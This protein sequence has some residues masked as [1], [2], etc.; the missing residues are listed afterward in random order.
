MEQRI[1]LSVL[2]LLCY[3]LFKCESLPQHGEWAKDM[4]IH[5]GDYKNLYENPTDGEVNVSQHS[6]HLWLFIRR[7][8][9]FCESFILVLD[10]LSIIAMQSSSSHG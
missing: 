9:R 5:D 3:Y 6:V 1:Q 10:Q 4:F 7:R 8:M 2:W